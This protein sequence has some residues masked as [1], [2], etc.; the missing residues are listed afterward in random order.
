VSL[1][2]LKI[3]NSLG[4]EIAALVEAEKDAGVYQVQWNARNAGSGIYILPIEDGGS[5]RN[6]ENDP[7]AIVPFVTPW[8]DE[9]ACQVN[10]R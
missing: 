6:R 7:S 4:Q 8:W 9:K 3:F 1:V 10:L 2:S 5:R